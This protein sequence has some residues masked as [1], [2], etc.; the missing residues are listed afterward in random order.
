LNAPYLEIPFD[1]T[2]TKAGSPVEL[3]PSSRKRA[4]PRR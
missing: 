1:F 3:S 2:L 4:E